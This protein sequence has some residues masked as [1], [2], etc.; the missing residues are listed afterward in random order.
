MALSKKKS[1]KIWIW[2][3]Y[4]RHTG[5]LIDW[6]SGDRDSLTLQKLLK[7]LSQWKVLF[8]C[9]DHWETYRKLIPSS[10]LFQGKDKTVAI[11]KNNGRQRHWIARFRRRSIVVT[12][13]LEM[14]NP[15]IALFA[16]VH[17]NHVW[18]LAKLSMN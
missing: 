4:C 5:R 11:E 3:A 12:K 13:S 15:H 18:S 9:T 2:K 6:E 10:Q 1:H 8:Y 17:I 7:R 16:A 14:L